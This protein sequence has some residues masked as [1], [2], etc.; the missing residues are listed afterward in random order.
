M[1]SDNTLPFCAAFV[2]IE[3]LKIIHKRIRCSGL[4]FTLADGDN[5]Y[6][7]T[8]AL[9]STAVRVSRSS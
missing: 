3:L 9:T 6:R 1:G 7:L 4:I 5:Q 8:F 2:K